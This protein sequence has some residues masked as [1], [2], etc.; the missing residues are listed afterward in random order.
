MSLQKMNIGNLVVQNGT[1]LLGL[2]LG[3]DIVGLD[4]LEPLRMG[5]FLVSGEVRRWMIASIQICDVLI[6]DSDL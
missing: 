1:G 4:D 6:V 3:E 2:Y 5:I